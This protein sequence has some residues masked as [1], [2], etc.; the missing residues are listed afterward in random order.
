MLKEDINAMEN[1]MLTKLRK[2]QQDLGEGVAHH[3]H[4]IVVWICT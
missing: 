3:D 2:I 1:L 4:S